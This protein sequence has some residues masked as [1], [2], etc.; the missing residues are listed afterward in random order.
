MI[1]VKIDGKPT[2]LPQ[3]WEEITEK[4]FLKLAPHLFP[5]PNGKI[6][7]Q[8]FILQ[9]LL[10]I[11]KRKFLKIRP[12]AIRDLALCLD[13]IF[14]NPSH[15]PGIRKFNW[16]GESYL[17]PKSKLSNVVG[18]E[19]AYADAQFQNFVDPKRRNPKALDK[20]LAALCRPQK[21]NLDIRNPEYNGDPREKFNSEIAEDR[22]EEFAKLPIEIK[23]TVLF[24]FVGCKKWIMKHFKFTSDEKSSTGLNLGWTGMLMDLAKTTVFGDFEKTCFTPLHTILV[25]L[26][27]AEAE[28]MEMKFKYGK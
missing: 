23:M 28:W 9:E 18:I 2:P 3:K 7:S 17:L 1:D 20:L 10:P 11:S 6:E 13:W 5:A 24:F 12:E 27:K 8:V 22:S 19:F 26:K 14:D 4:Q 25:Y 21:V 16:K 15:I